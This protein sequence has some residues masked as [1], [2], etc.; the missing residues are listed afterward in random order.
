MEYFS[1]I[2]IKLQENL[3]RTSIYK[4]SCNDKQK[5]GMDFHDGLEIID[6]QKL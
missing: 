4:K 3:C 6:E 2:F 5:D 1:I